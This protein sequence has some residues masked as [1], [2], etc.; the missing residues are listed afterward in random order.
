MTFGKDIIDA[1][2]KTE[3]VD[4]YCRILLLVKDIGEWNQLTFEAMERLFQIKTKMG[5]PDP[6]LNEDLKTICQTEIPIRSE[7]QKPVNKELI[8]KIVKE[9]LQRINDQTTLG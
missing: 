8:D 2:H 3:Q 6:R 5:I 7:G 9:V 4:Q 1:Y